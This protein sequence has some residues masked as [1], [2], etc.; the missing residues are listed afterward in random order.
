MWGKRSD[1]VVHGQSPFNAEP[2]RSALAGRGITPLDT[3]NS[4]NHGPI[5]AIAPQEWRLAVTGLVTHELT[6]TFDELTSRFI[7]CSV[8]AT[9]QCA[10]NRRAGFTEVRKIPGEDPWGPCAT[11]TAEWRGVRLRDVLDAAGAHTGEGLYVAFTAPDVSSLASPAQSYG[12]SIPLPKARSDEVLLAWETPRRTTTSRP[13]PT[14]FF[15]LR[16]TRTPPD[17]VT[18]SRCPRSR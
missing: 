2:S 4:R 15:R 16:P 18:E 1:T 8:V 7:P 12:S 9:L 17:Q 13:P 3:F 11:S 14:G 6:F 5:P 10:G